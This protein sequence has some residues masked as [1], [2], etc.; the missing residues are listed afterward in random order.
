VSSPKAQNLF[1]GSICISYY[2][3]QTIMNQSSPNSTSCQIL[4]QARTACRLKS[5]PAL[6]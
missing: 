1:C 2:F 3:T 6:I 5:S 4:V